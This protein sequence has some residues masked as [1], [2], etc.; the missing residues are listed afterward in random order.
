[1]SMRK[2][3]CATLAVAGLG[4][5]A[6]PGKAAEMLPAKDS[7]NS[8][9]FVTYALGYSMV[10]GQRRLFVHTGDS[11]YQ[12][13]AVGGGFTVHT[14]GL[15]S[16][17]GGDQ[18]VSDMGFAAGPDGQGLVMMGSGG[19][20]LVVDLTTA[21]GA[22][23]NVQVA[24]DVDGGNAT[25]NNFYS[26]A[27]RAAGRFYAMF[28][29]PDYST[30]TA[31]YAIT[32]GAATPTQ[33][34]LDP[35]VSHPFNSGPYSGGMGFDA[36]GNLYFGTLGY[37]PSQ[38]FPVATVQFF[39]V[40]STDLDAFEAGG[41]APTATLLGEGIAN[42]NGASWAVAPD[43]TLYFN[44]ATG[45]GRFKDGAVS[46]L[47]GSLTANFPANNAIEGLAYNPD[48]DELVFG[49]WN[50]STGS[51]QYELTFVPVAALAPEPA[52]G[53]LLASGLVLLT[54]RR[55]R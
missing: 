6:G 28:V 37:H 21:P 44:T 8:Y 36:A 48:T 41:A 2:F 50:G 55:R 17:F 18:R 12:R 1:M 23:G 5:L 24:P 27:S 16:A 54:L 38:V 7:G 33:F 45:I 11:L 4:V 15:R 31:I 20:A 39:R 42:G 35:R 30:N 9:G 25:D 40:A 19:G 13:N 52:A 34:V 22:G 26:A 10:D 43:G 29:A 3:L 51:P 47:Y 32:P 49:V 46:T 53:L 14:T